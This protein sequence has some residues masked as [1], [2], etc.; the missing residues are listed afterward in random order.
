MTEQDLFDADEAE[1]ER[2][3]EEQQM[4]DMYEVDDH[5]NNEEKQ[6]ILKHRWKL[7]QH[8][9]TMQV[10]YSRLLKSAKQEP[11]QVYSKLN[12]LRQPKLKVD[13]QGI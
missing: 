11:L 4:K 7:L 5:E 12:H 6:P 1:E 8:L 2:E 9:V 10:L 3:E 13:L